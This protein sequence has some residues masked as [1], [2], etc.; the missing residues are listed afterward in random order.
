MAEPVRSPRAAEDWSAAQYLK[1]EEERTRPSRDLLAQVPL[2]APRRVVDLGCGP[3]NSTELLIGRFP[4]AE[5][6]GVDSS[7][8]MLRQARERLPRCKFVEADLSAWTPEAG[9][10][11]LFGNAVFH[12]V[13]DH[14]S[15]LRRLLHALGPGG[16]LAVQMPDNA[17]EPAFTVLE[18][19][20]ASGPWAAAIAQTKGRQRKQ[21]LRPEEY[22]DLFRPLCS[23]VDIWHI[24]YNHLMENHAGVVEWFKGSGLR[25]LLAPLDAAVRAAFLSRYTDEISRAYP[26]RC[27]GNVMLRFPRLFIVAVRGGGE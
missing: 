22:Y 21:L 6:I 19:V 24:H 12:W 4:G 27:D 25:P 2:D 14:P 15:V 13:P 10:D 5:V 7:P 17:N 9:T 20:I 26:P 8:D 23:H 18:K 16:V 1:F 11:L 3:G